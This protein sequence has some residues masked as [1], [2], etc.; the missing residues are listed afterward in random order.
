M[1]SRDIW[2]PACSVFLLNCEVVCL[3]VH[4]AIFAYLTREPTLTVRIVCFVVGTASEVAT[5]QGQCDGYGAILASTMGGVLSRR[6][7]V[8]V[9]DLLPMFSRSH[10]MEHQFI[11]AS[12]SK[13]IS[14]GV[15][16]CLRRDKIHRQIWFCHS[17]PSMVQLCLSWE[18]RR[19]YQTL[20]C[21]TLRQVPILRPS[22]CQSCC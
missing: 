20:S 11:F 21:S 6:Y 22:T 17:R 12:M 4:S 2:L 14:I 16:P 13:E 5:Q 1:F 8:G 3:D 10:L 15:C 9:R 19:M 18:P 7:D